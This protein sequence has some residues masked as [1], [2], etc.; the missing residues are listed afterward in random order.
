MA[1]WLVLLVLLGCGH[2]VSGTD[3]Q[4]EAPPPSPGFKVV[5]FQEVGLVPQA[6]VIQARD[7]ARS[8]LLWG[9]SVWT[10]DTTVLN[11]NDVYGKNWHNSSFSATADLAGSDGLGGFIDTLDTAGAPVRLLEPTAD[12]A[13]YNANH[14][15][16]PCQV[17][18]CGAYYDS[19]PTAA[20]WDAQ[21]TRALLFYHLVLLQPGQAELRL[22]QSIALWSSLDTVPDRPAVSQAEHPTQMFQQAEPA[23]GAAAQVVDS[24]VYAFSCEPDASKLVSPCK[25][26]RVPLDA[27]LA[28]SSWQFWD[29]AAFSSEL[30]AAADVFTGN[31]IMTVAWNP[32]IN[33]WLAVYSEPLTSVVM[34]RSATALTG[35]WSEQ[36]PL[37]KTPAPSADRWTFDAALHDEYSENGGQTLYVS[38]SRPDPANGVYGADVAWVRVDI[39]AMP[40]P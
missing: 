38:Y 31:W 28:R 37:F 1:R 40:L 26:A 7:G 5:S 2:V 19:R 21:R 12:E 8:T 10:F 18:P 25:L 16:S 6:S 11:E 4:G 22:G 36:V 24:D 35:P 32:H 3:A 20:V 17:A 29:G 34:A 39:A 9:K 30:A 23:F 15:G 33:R 27:L 14:T 13:A